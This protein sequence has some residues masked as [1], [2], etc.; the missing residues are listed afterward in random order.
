MQKAR[1][2]GLCRVVV[3]RVLRAAAAI[4]LALAIGNVPAAATIPCSK[5]ISL[6]NRLVRQQPGNS[7]N[8]VFIG[9]KLNADPLWVERCLESYG[10]RVTRR[11]PPPDWPM[12]DVEENWESGEFTEESGVRTQV[13]A[14]DE[15]ESGRKKWE[16]LLGSRRP[17]QQPTPQESS[18]SEAE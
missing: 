16:Q 4:T 7:R 5:I 18:G 3:S 6:S 13:E 12:E 17:P 2:G 1:R 14:Q 8:A 9:R 11:A 10:R 15:K